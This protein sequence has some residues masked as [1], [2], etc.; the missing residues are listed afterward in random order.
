L[1]HKK[2]DEYWIEEYTSE[3]GEKVKLWECPCCGYPT[4][5]Q[6]DHYE[7]CYLC[8]WEDDGQEDDDADRVRGG[9]NSDYSLTEARENFKKY[10][11][12]YR[13]HDGREDV[14]DN[15]T[16]NSIKMQIIKLFKEINKNNREE[17]IQKIIELKER[18]REELDIIYYGKARKN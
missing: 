3:N 16:I 15:K 8:D 2:T 13:P 18:M 9:P 7:I 17:T 12:M 10:L 5:T 1:G 6:L 11:N 4:L 14:F